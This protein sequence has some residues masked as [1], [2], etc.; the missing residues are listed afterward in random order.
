M[1]ELPKI[2]GVNGDKW[3][4]RGELGGSQAFNVIRAAPHYSE[5]GRSRHE[6][7]VIEDCRVRGVVHRVVRVM[8]SGCV[9]VIGWQGVKNALL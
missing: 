4:N 3:Q 6:S 1:G 9:V 8:V 2:A 5:E 7:H